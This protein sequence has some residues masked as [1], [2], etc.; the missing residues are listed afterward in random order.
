MVLPSA[1]IWDSQ[2]LLEHIIS[3]CVFKCNIDRCRLLKWTLAHNGLV[4]NAPLGRAIN[5]LDGVVCRIGNTCGT[6]VCVCV[7]VCTCV[8]VT[9][10]E[11]I[12]LC[13]YVEKEELAGVR[14]V[15]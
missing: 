11:R 15:D 5:L 1:F 9:E 12:K 13:M 6:C 2:E 14:R 10:T 8:C 4:N 3:S 7:C